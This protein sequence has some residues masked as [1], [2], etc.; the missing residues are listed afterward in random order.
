MRELEAWHD[1]PPA[2][3]GA[4][5]L[6]GF[7]EAKLAAGAHPNTVRKY[8]GMVRAH[9]RRKYERGRVS[10]EVL[11]DVL[12][13]KPPPESSRCAHP[14]PYR[15]KELSTLWATLDERWPKLDDDEASH[16]LR[17]WLDGR[18]PYS[19]M[20]TH[21][22]RS[23]LDAVIALALYCGLRRREIFRL[24]DDSMHDDN[25]CVVVWCDETA[26]WHGGK[27]RTVSYTD[28]ARAR[29]APWCRIRSALRTDHSRAWLNLH[30]ERTVREPMSRHVFNKVPRT[31]LG[32]GWTFGRLR[33]TCAVNWAK[34]GLLPEHLRQVLGY[35]SLNDVL[36]F[37]ALVGGDAER[38]MNRRED[39]FVDQLSPV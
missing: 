11:L 12:S 24:D 9:Y 16:R 26:P 25:A 7:L 30:A 22:I 13:I 21:A 6:T 5:A 28:S 3:I 10:A 27:Y 29:I 2:E 34:A 37:L 33:A 15:R 19:R 36:P 39:A 32:A 23:Q 4:E 35:S 20:R 14:Q 17:R 31:Y 18:S 8:L 1:G 38:E